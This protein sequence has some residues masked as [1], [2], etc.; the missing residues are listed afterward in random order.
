[1][2]RVRFLFDEDFNGHIVRGFRRRQPKVDTC[3]APEAGLRGADD[4]AILDWS[5]GDGRVLVSHDRRT[6]SAEARGRIRATLPMAGLILFRQD[7]PIGLAIEELVL[8]SEATAAE[9]WHD[10]IAFLPL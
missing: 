5:A 9:E 1:M 2:S 3:T 4:R 10:T 6:M 7:C 8:V